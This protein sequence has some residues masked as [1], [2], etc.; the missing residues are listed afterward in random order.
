[1]NII[2]TGCG[3]IGSALTDTLSKEGHNVSVIEIN[4]ETLDNIAN[5]CDV[6]GVEG[7]GASVVTQKDAGVEAA[8]LLIAT[9]GS[10]EVNLLCCLIAKKVNKEIST[11]ARVRNPV[12]RDE[13]QYFKEEL[14]LSLV[15][16]PE[17][18][19]AIEIARLL[20][21]PAA[22]KVD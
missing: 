21:F 5:S 20:R 15:L 4:R 3:K 6:I 8:N 10:D 16:N 19:A 13:I 11:I 1:M 7:N 17:L 22:M 18:T 12:Y 2:I 14:G 9:T